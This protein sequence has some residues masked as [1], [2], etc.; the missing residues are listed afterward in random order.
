VSAWLAPLVLALTAG[1]SN[2]GA[3]RPPEL[4]VAPP[5]PITEFEG[6]RDIAFRYLGRPYRMGGVGSPHIDCSGFTCRVY[7]EAGYAIPRVSRDQAN[8][9]VPVSLDR[10]APGDLVFFVAEPG[11]SRITHVGL[12]LGDDQ[13]IHASSGQGEVV[14][15]DLRRS[16]YQQRIVKARRF[17]PDPGAVVTSSTGTTRTSSTGRPPVALKTRWELPASELVEHTGGSLLPITKRLP[18]AQPRPSLGPQIAWSKVTNLALRAAALTEDGVLGLT[19]V[20]EGTFAWEDWALTVSLAVPIR[21]ELNEPVTVGKLDRFADWT[22]FVREASFGLPGADLELRFDRLGDVTLSGGFLVDR[23]APGLSSSGVPG[24]SVGRTPLAFFGGYRGPIVAEAL[25]ADV[26]DPA[27]AGLAIGVPIFDGLDVS[28]VVV[29][30]Q[31]ANAADARRAINALGVHAG[32]RIWEASQWTVGVAADGALTVAGARDGSGL[33]LTASGEH[34]FGG[35][36]SVGLDLRV[37][38]LGAGFLEA[39]FGPTYLAA[40]PAHFA[41]LLQTEGRWSLGAEALVRWGRASFGAGYAD[42]LGASAH[43]LDRRWFAHAALRG[44]PA[45]G[46]RLL[47]LRL[48]YAAR[49]LP[50]SRAEGANDVLHGSIRLRLTRWLAAQ[51]YVE[52]SDRFEGGVGIAA[53]WAP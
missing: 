40:R 44:I 48:V 20:P 8:A 11:T 50:G 46:T 5:P 28:G 26:G 35:G 1:P 33:G 24:L 2:L 14:V 49:G 37:S 30:D 29:T 22:R 31:A 12:Y 27:L 9:G 34:R 3:W 43:L 17:L 7:A 47:D 16:W 51:L 52:E 41:A 25:I 39:P 45:G 10:L 13:M 18:L 53:T 4:R 6:V 23:L 19:L 32:Y 42:G 21:F 38:R 36:S 15:A